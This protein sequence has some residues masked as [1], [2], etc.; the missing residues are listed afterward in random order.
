MRILIRILQ[1]VLPLALLGLAGWGALTMIRNRPVVETQPAQIAPPGVRVHVVALE[2]VDLA[3]FSE[4]TVRPRTES[5]LVPEISGRIMSVAPSFAEGGFFE[6][7]DILVTIDPFDYEQ[8]V[9]SARAQLAQSRLRLAEEEAEAEVAGREWEQLGRGDPRELTLRTPHLEDARAAVAAAEANLVRAER[10]LERAEIQAP[11]AGRV[12]RKNVDVGQFVTVGAAIATIYAVDVAEIRLPLPDEELAYLN[13][14]LAY[15]GGANRQGPRVTVRT[16][17]AGRTYAWNGRIVRT[18]SEIDPVSRMVHVVAEVPNP[19]RP[20]PGPDQPPLAVGMYVDAEIE[21][22]RFERIASVPRAALRGRDQV[23][24]VDEDDR[25]R[26]RTID[27][28]RMTAA[29]IYVREGL[30]SGDRVV[31]ST[32]DSPTDGMLVQV[33]NPGAAPDADAGAGTD[34]GTA[35]AADAGSAAVEAAA[36]GNAAADARPSEPAGGRARAERPAD[37]QPAPPQTAAATPPASTPAPAAAPAPDLPAAAPPAPAP[38]DPRAVAVLPFTNISDAAAA[39]GLGD[40]L[41]QGV[42]ERLGAMD[43]V[44]VVPAAASAR[45]VIGGAVRQDDD[46]V[47]VT[48]RIVETGAGAVVQTVQMDGAASELPRLRE[49]VNTAVAARLADAMGTVTAA[50]PTPPPAPPVPTPVAPTPAV[51]APV[52]PAPAVPAP[53]V[54]APVVPAPA[55]RATPPAASGATVA[56]RPFANLSRDPADD[57]LASGVGQAVA[58]HL[59]GTGTFTVE[60]AEDGARWVVAGGIQRVGDQIRITARLL[61]ARAGT[62]VRSV[63]VDGP[64]GDLPR[65]RDEIAATLTGGLQEML[66]ADAANAA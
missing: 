25:L 14:P 8:A 58:A 33:A 63:K 15:R 9:I 60:A 18:E 11:Y 3:V 51:P 30:S 56:V 22:R 6:A 37:A 36:V 27:V 54:P 34:P 64:V 66:D 39:S 57:D 19:Y 61:D 2:D 10:D 17:F 13:L 24:V 21:G 31:V 20:G 65:L 62:V 50:A 46:V 28:L 49:A 59:A 47:Q 55:A 29:S 43:T 16:T 32:V 5:Q 23:M 42:W 41:A 7:G 4:G 40:A 53:A 48:A 1:G 38:T 35:D 44:T 26:F 52:V 12:R 45:W